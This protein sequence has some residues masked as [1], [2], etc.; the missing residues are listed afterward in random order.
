MYSSV[1]D[2]GK[3]ISLIFRDDKLAKNGTNQ[4]LDGASIRET[5]AQ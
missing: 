4:T 5:F 2:L 3:L 1:R